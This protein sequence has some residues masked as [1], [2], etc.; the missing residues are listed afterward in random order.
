[1]GEGS[2]PAPDDAP[3]PSEQLGPAP[4]IPLPPAEEPPKAPWFAIVSATVVGLVAIAGL[5]VFAARVPAGGRTAGSTSSETHYRQS[6]PPVAADYPEW[7]VSGEP[8][9]AA[10]EGDSVYDSTWQ[11]VY[12]LTSKKRPR[13]S[14]EAGY[15]QGAGGHWYAVEQTFSGKFDTPKV[16]ELLAAMTEKHPGGMHI[17]RMVRVDEFQYPDADAVDYDSAEPVTTRE[18]VAEWREPGGLWRPLRREVWAYDL[19]AKV[20]R[21]DPKDP[22]LLDER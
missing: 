2:V 1:M 5:V 20:W 11:L 14:I 15:Y 17:V 12:R 7:E 9:R 19:E 8:S 16:D 13:L 10:Y 3:A 6:Q 18:Y 21:F 4:R 22:P